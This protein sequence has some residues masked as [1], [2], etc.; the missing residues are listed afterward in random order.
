MDY[1]GEEEDSLLG[2][3]VCDGSSLDPLGEFVNGHQQ[4]GVPSCRPLERTHEVEDP[5]REWPSD[6]DHL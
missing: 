6:G 4:V 3:K 2:V 1:V 5:Y